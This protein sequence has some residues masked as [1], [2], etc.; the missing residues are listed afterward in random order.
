MIRMNRAVVA[1]TLVA[2][3]T[4]TA[5]AQS[6]EN[7]EGF[8]IGG[9]IGQFNVQIDDLDETDEA[10]ETLDDDDNAWKAFGGWRLN[11]YFAVELAYIDFGGPADRFDASGTSGDFEIDLSGFAPY[12]IGTIPLG[13][14]ELFGKVGYYFYDIDFNVDLDDPTFPDVDGGASDE[15]LLYGFG[16]GVTLFERLHARLEYEKIDSDL[17]DDADALW[18]SG[19]W[20]F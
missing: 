13:P 2:L 19:A 20:R 9:G 3:G 16:A 7:D 6:P 4:G 15:D 18:L 17:L 11:P 10:V 14:V 1:A 12:I 8:Y 5:Y